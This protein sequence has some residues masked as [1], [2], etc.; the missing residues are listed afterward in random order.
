M[1]NEVV[2]FFTK[3]TEVVAIDLSLTVERRDEEEE[4]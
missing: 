1:L 3:V 2:F 4:I